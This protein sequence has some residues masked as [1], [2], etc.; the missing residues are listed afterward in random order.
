MAAMSARDRGKGRRS[1]GLGSNGSGGCPPAAPTVGTGPLGPSPRSHDHDPCSRVRRVQWRSE[2]WRPHL[3]EETKGASMRTCTELTAE[4]TS[5]RVRSFPPT[6]PEVGVSPLDRTL[7]SEALTVP[8]I[9]RIRVGGRVL[10]GLSVLVAPGS[11]PRSAQ[12]VL[13]GELCPAGA[14]IARQHLDDLVERGVVCIHVDVSKLRLCTTAGVEVFEAIEAEVTRRGGGLWLQGATGV[15]A[16]VFQVLD[17]RQE[18][19]ARCFGSVEAVVGRRERR[20]RVG[21][22]R[23]PRHGHDRRR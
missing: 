9:H 15:V 3:L 7:W 5:C 2:P 22:R 12:V 6:S 21:D 20:Q 4:G 1:V 10:L 13:A 8:E 16:R 17:V 11:R 23:D 18:R 19:P 14:P